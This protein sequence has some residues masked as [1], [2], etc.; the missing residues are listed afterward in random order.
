MFENSK[1][2]YNQIPKS[3]FEK[4]LKSEKINDIGPA[5]S[6]LF[7]IDNSCPG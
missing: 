5:L 4:I 2:K 7:I 1:T 6:K 3:Y